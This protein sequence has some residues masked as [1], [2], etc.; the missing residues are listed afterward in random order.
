MPHNDLL[1]PEELNA[2]LREVDWGRFDD[3]ASGQAED[4]KV[5]PY[6][7]SAQERI[8]RSSMPALEMI[9]EKFSRQ[10][11]T[12]LSGVL[13]RGAAVDLAR[14]ESLR[15]SDWFAQLPPRCGIHL[16]KVHPLH[17]TG[18]FVLPPR[19]VSLFVDSNFGGRAEDEH[20][21]D[22]GVEQRRE[23]T[24]AEL[25]I[26]RIV[27]DRI[28]R[29]LE[30]AW[31]PVFKIAIEHTGVETNP[32]FASIASPPE[33]VI[34][35]QFGIRLGSLQGELSFVIPYS[36]VEPIKALLD[37]GM[38]TGHSD[39]D[40]R[41]R[42]KL[43]ENLLNVSLELR[44]T[45][46]ETILPVRRILTMKTGD[47]IPIDLP[48]QLPVDLEG[49]PAYRGA[50]GSARGRNAVKIT[51]V[52][53]RDPDRDLAPEAGVAS[54]GLGTRGIGNPAVGPTGQR[55]QAGFTAYA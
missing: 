6:D 46:V 52:L 1:T 12:T 53:H 2:L 38:L 17:G 19:L 37:N 11:R 44:G 50:L 45:L 5:A 25:R 34:A 24:A 9:Y 32:L 40:L 51:Q 21:D 54:P 55:Q 20:M 28:A 15:Y 33:R 4:R 13:R 41:W 10:L 36:M 23:I 47:V 3:E 39:V 30:G 27:I 49:T 7:F 48:K 29:D 22:E 35:A 16:V 8:V 18:L 14:V 31:A 26:T 43:I 42:D